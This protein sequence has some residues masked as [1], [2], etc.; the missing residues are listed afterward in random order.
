[1]RL[2]ATLPAQ[3]KAASLKFSDIFEYAKPAADGSCP[4]GF[5]SV[6]TGD[7]LEECLKLKVRGACFIGGVLY[8]CSS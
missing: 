5:K 2:L 3:S 1:M 7:R 4:A 8:E 6:N